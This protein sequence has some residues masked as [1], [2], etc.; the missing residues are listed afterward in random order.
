MQS[1][2]VKS[3]PQVSTGRVTDGVSSYLNRALVGTQSEK[4][5]CLPMS[6]KKQQF[7]VLPF[8]SGD[9][10]L[11]FG[12]VCSLLRCSKRTL[13]RYSH[14]YI[15]QTKNP[16]TGKYE[17]VARVRASLGFVRRGGNILFPKSAVEAFIAKRT[18]NAA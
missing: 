2:S 12:E 10:L 14:G 6:T 15:R 11:T 18:V 7:A 9:P 4:D 16:L 17:N 5:W 1:P 8:K 3:A 13:L